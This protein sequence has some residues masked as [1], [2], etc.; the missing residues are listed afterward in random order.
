MIRERGK[1]GHDQKYKI[2]HYENVKTDIML[3]T[4]CH[5]TV[6]ETIFIRE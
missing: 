4:E 3:I 6:T 1:Q 2:H 5:D